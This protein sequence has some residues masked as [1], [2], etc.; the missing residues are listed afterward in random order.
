MT[1]AVEASLRRVADDLTGVDARW[2]LVGG[3]AVSSRAE[4]RFTAD[5]QA[6][7]PDVDTGRLTPVE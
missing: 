2:A 4:P 1:G 3:F 5:R 7:A 6:P